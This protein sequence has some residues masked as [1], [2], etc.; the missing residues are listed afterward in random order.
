M[1]WYRE[2]RG[3]RASSLKTFESNDYATT[4]D[5]GS[6]SEPHSV[7]SDRGLSKSD[8]AIWIDGR[9]RI[10]L[11]MDGHVSTI[12]VDSEETEQ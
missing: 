5:H 8:N 1:L 7:T 6:G 3:R 10:T 2:I 4:S 12:P 11:D 9:E